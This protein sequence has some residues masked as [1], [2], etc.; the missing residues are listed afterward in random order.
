MGRILDLVDSPYDMRQLGY[1]ELKKLA[2]EIREEIIGTIS[3]TGGH[4]A[5][6]LGVVELSM[7]LHYVFNTPEDKVIWDVGHQCYAH[8]IIT[9]RKK[10]FSTIRQ[11]DGIS[12]FPKK[13]ESE[14]DNFGTGHSSTSISAALGIATARDLRGEKFNVVAVIGD[15]AMTGGMAFEAMNNAG[16]MNTNLIV[17][18][19]DNEMS[20]SNNVGS[21]TQHLSKIRMSR[22]L[23]K[24]R[25]D[26]RYIVR[27]IPKVGKKVL[28]VCEYIEDRVTYL[29]VPGVIF[30]A[31]GFFYLGPFDGHNIEQLVKTFE[32]VKNME[33][34]IMVHVITQ[35]GKGYPPAEKDATKFH[36]A[37]PFDIATGRNINGAEAPT[38]TEVFGN[39]LTEMARQDK[40]IVAVTAAMR[41][42]TGLSRF[43]REFP[44]RFFDVGIAEQH[45]V[46]FSAALACGGMRPVVAIYSTFLQRAFDQLIHDVCLQ[47][48][49]VLFA[50]DRAG[51]VGE[52]GPT[53]HGVFDISYLRFVPNLVLMSPCDENELR[54][55]MKTALMID[56]PSAIRFPREC[57]VGVAMEAETKTLETGKA[58]VIREGKDI[59]I[60]AIGNLV[61]PSIFAAERLSVYGISAT[62]INAR[63]IKPL[64]EELILS[65][66]RKTRRIIT[67]EENVVT[68]GFGS[69]V[70]EMIHR[71]GYENI[72]ITTLGLPDRFIE[73]GSPS[74]LK[75]NLGI[76]TEGITQAILKSLQVM[77]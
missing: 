37:A 27:N 38:Y 65:V 51:I 1:P 41:D 12:G 57:G 34:N 19:N 22:R 23:Q 16:S 29:L 4:L 2:E 26:L 75:E 28:E 62:V 71:S 13:M 59:A 73:Q 17:V 55:M 35:K 42:G 58:E 47:N 64:D 66:A 24:V 77:V 30:E 72:S 54:A 74:I 67:V 69:A 44:D 20:I 10:S 52:D 43:A 46:T 25:K 50:I 61:Y 7:A 36:A 48:L 15:G 49:P 21:L 53:H 33:G 76:T 39:T 5:S 9:G 68:G 63:F 32:R 14:F 3:K 8:K 40:R 18:L 70:Q 45:A 31:L 60:I 6:S 11:Y 56:G